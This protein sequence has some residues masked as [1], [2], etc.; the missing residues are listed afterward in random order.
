MTLGRILY[1]YPTC[2]LGAGRI[3]FLHT[4]PE[5]RYGPGPKAQSEKESLLAQIGHVCLGGINTESSLWK[6]YCEPT[7]QRQAH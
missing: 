7:A 2:L 4:W 5:G 3:P 1:P 6:G